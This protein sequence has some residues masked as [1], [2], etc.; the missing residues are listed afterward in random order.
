MQVRC[1]IRTNRK[2]HD[3]WSKKQAV[4]RRQSPHYWQSFVNFIK[5][6][7]WT[8]WE[9]LLVRLCGEKEA[10]RTALEELLWH[11]VKVKGIAQ[12][13][14]KCTCLFSYQEL[15]E[16]RHTTVYWIRSLEQK[17]S[18]LSVYRVEKGKVARLALSEYKKICLL[19]LTRYLS[20]D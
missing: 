18:K 2:K 12:H 4:R 9:K 17:V 11:G 7:V 15:A 14:G 16:K 13:F 19:A 5:I 1:P 10:H 20:F 3:F 6:A 8:L